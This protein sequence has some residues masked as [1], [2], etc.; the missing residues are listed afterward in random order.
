[1]DCESFEKLERMTIE[2]SQKVGLAE[3]S[4]LEKQCLKSA[5]EFGELFDAILLDDPENVE[6]EMGDL[7]VVLI[8]ICDRY[9]KGK[10]T[11]ADCLN[12]AFEKISVRTG[13]MVNG[14]FVKD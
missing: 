7:L 14:N 10:K 12:V 13:K 6:E 1:M 5:A 2:W 3:G 8:Q 9:F 11:L 4:T